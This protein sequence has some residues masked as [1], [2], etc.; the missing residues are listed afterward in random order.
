MDL[1]LNNKVVFFYGGNIG[2]AQDMMNIVRL[3][4]SLS[5]YP[6]AHFLL[7]GQGDEVKLILDSVS[8]N[9]IKNLSY[10]GPVNQQ[11][12]QEMLIEFDVG[13]FSL[14]RNHKTHNFPGKLLGY[15]KY[16]KPILGS[17]NLGND[18]KSVLMD[19]EAGFVTINGED[20]ALTNNA[21]KLLESVEI[22]ESM[23][24][25]ALALLKS[26]F[27]VSSAAKKITGIFEN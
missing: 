13:L 23:G 26:T 21:L 22:R 3:A 20:S 24:A 9:S 27:S 4:Q 1:G 2:H 5:G 19:C 14:H 8:R 10:L 12:Y 6:Q 25:N 15:M 18:L 16:S 7:V 11:E 17:V